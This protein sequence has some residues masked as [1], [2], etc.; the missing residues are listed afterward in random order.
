MSTNTLPSPER[1][2]FGVEIEFMIATLPADKE[3][4]DPDA[5]VEGLP[6]VLRIP[7]NDGL[8]GPDDYLQD[9]TLRSVRRVIHECFGPPTS[10]T[11]M[12]SSS[13]W[14]VNP[15]RV[16]DAYRNWV[17]DHDASIVA[18]GSKPY[19]F[20]GVEVSSP[21]QFSSPKGFNA[22]SFA[23]SAITSQFR[24]MVNFSCGLHVH[25]GLGIERLPLEH[26]RRIASL[27]YAAE[28]LLFTLHDPIR[29]VNNYCKPLQDYSYLV[30]ETVEQ[31]LETAVPHSKRRDS[32]GRRSGN[33]CHGYL[34]RERRH[35]EAPLSVRDE[36]TDKAHIEAFLE[37]RQRGH[38]EPFTKPGDSRHTKLLPDISDELVPRLSA[39]R[40]SSSA[41]PPAEKAEKARQRNIPRLRLPQHSSPQLWAKREKLAPFGLAT[42]A[43][44]VSD[45][46]ERGPGP[47]VFEAARRIYSQPASCYISELLSGHDRP[48]ISFNAYKC[49]ALSPRSIMRTIEFRLGEGSLESGWI[50]TWAKICV[51]LFKFALYSSPDQFIDVLTNCDRAM[52]EDGAYDVIDLLD[53]IGLFAEAEIAERRLMANKD[54]WNLTFVEPE[55]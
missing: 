7:E 15:M 11:P 35:G 42:P 16:L 36:H 14:Q 29:R 49:S 18:I 10:S 31:A 5:N 34:G 40:L 52:K 24:C 3:V 46:D 54:R 47:G 32:K 23:I 39:A 17:V 25:A 43:H 48:A 2:T 33:E 30:T 50:S 37:T 1:P 19:R 21:V 22:I 20:V 44:L 53:D 38:F 28:S 51:G 4:L 55:S 26:V 45:L 12:S 41:I 27:T 8:L 9:Y 13:R 6:P